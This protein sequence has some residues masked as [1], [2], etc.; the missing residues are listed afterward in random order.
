M[1]CVPSMLIRSLLLPGV[2]DRRAETYG[3]GPAG[4]VEQP[5]P[6]IFFAGAR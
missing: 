3:A 6:A 5:T 2:D 4:A 1:V